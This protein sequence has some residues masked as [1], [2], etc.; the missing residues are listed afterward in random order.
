MQQFP[1]LFL[2]ELEP[3]TSPACLDGLP[4]FKVHHIAAA[5]GKFEEFL[6]IWETQL[7]GQGGFE[8]I[9]EELARPCSSEDKAEVNAVKPCGQA[10]R[11]ELFASATFTVR[12]VL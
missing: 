7:P 1:I 12:A 9:L 2:H 4:P 11:A 10:G 3:E 6:G 5:L 8:V